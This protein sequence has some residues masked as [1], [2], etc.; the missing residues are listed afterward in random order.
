M[1]FFWTNKRIRSPAILEPH[2]RQDE[3]VTSQSSVSVEI[4]KWVPPEYQLTD[5]LGSETLRSEGH[6]PAERSSLGTRKSST[7]YNASEPLSVVEN[8]YSTIKNYKE[9][10]STFKDLFRENNGGADDDSWDGSQ[11]GT[12]IPDQEKSLLRTM[13]M[14]VGRGAEYLWGKTRKSIARLR[15]RDDGHCC[16]W[17]T[18]AWKRIPFV[19]T[20]QVYKQ[21]YFLKDM[22]AGITEGIMNIPLGR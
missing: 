17:L 19:K 11:G 15:E 7:C 16:G 22:T 13:S 18:K 6:I 5:E 2:L 12:S 9:F 20:M 3:S 8:D 4:F 10:Q 14:D 21:V 1:N